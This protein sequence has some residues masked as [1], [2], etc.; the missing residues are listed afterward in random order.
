MYEDALGEVKAL[1]YCVLH[2]LPEL[3]DGVAK[4]RATCREPHSGDSCVPAVCLTCQQPG[5][6]HAPKHLRNRW[7]RNTYALGQIGMP[8]T[9]LGPELRQDLLLASV[10]PE[11]D[12]ALGHEPSMGFRHPDKEIG[13]A[14]QQRIFHRA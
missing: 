13:H 1:K 4:G 10:Q 6:L 2:R 8:Q 3:L 11:L 14:A 5:T 12:K 9:V 7:R